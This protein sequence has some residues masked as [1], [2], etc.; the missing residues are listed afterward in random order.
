MPL[1]KGK[2][3]KSFVKNLKTEMEHGK[4]QKQ[5]LAIAYAMKRKASR[6]KMADG[7]P[8]PS[9]TP[10]PTPEPTPD[11]Q[12]VLDARQSVSDSFNSVIKHADGGRINKYEQGVHDPDPF[13]KNGGE[14]TPG[15]W[16]REKQPEK[17]H[18]AE[19]EKQN[20]RN[21]D[22]AKSAHSDKLEQ[23]K[24]MPKPKLQ[25]L[26]EGGEVCE[27]CGGKMM[28]DGGEIEEEM[29]S[30]YDIPDE[31]YM[32]EPMESEEDLVDRIMHQ[33][34]K[35]ADGDYLEGKEMY[36]HAEGKM[37]DVTN[38]Y[39]EGGK[40]ANSD[41]I[42][43]GFDPNEFDDLHLRDD[44]SSSYGEDDNAGDDLGNKQEDEDRADLV[45]RI[46]LRNFKQKIPRG[47]PGR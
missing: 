46:M 23:L 15:N 2:S 40:V 28:A 9:P 6:K 7:G 3:E 32:E 8:T 47:Y 16:A 4:P 10:S 39:S 20:S 11:D 18:S 34:K 17:M 27:H 37:F 1:I 5:S 38:K 26:A 31:K 21:M 43:A 36:P 13:S 19:K 29:Q 33:R 35:M 41:E 44:L 22:L 45:D 12:S 42:E 30:G 25:G 14:S 24:S